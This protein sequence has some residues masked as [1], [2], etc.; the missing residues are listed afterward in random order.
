MNH[1][2]LC[3]LLI[4]ADGY[5]N[6]KDVDAQRINDE[7]T[8][9]GYCYNDDC[10]T[11]EARINALTTYILMLFKS[12]IR[13]D[14]YSEYDECFLMWLS[15][16][17]FKIHSKSKDKNKKITLSQAYDM[18]L[19]KHKAKLGHWFL[20]D[21]IKGLKNAD[22]KYMSEF[23]K[24]LNKI[25]ITIT[26]YSENGTGSKNII[27][28]STECSNQYMMLYNWFSEC[29]SYLH[30]L[31]KLKYIYDRFRKPAMKEIRRNKLSI[32][33]QTLT[34]IAGVEMRSSKVFKSYDFSNSQC[35]SKKK[36]TTIPKKEE[37]PP[38]PLKQPKDSQDETSPPS[39]SSNALPKTKTGE[40][41]SSDVQDASKIDLKTSDNSEGKTKD[42]SGDQGSPGS[43]TRDAS[44]VPGGQIS[45]GN[46][47]GTNI[48]QQGTDGGSGHGTGNRGTSS[49]QEGD[50]GGDKGSSS[51]EN[52]SPVG[53]LNDQVDSGVE[54]GKKIGGA[55]EP[56]DPSDGKGSQV[57]GGDRTSIES[58]G[59]DTGKGGPGNSDNEKGVKDSG[60]GSPS[61][62]TG[63]LGGGLNGQA[64]SG[65]ESRNMN[66]EV[67]EPGAPRGGEGIQINKGDGPNGE[68]D[69][70]NAGKEGSDGGSGSSN[71]EQGG[72]DS[73]PG[74]SSSGTEN[75]GRKSSD[76]DLGSNTEDKKNLQIDKGITQDNSMKQ[77]EGLSKSGGSV[78]NSPKDKEST[79]NTMEQHQQNNSL[80]SNPKEKPQDSQK[81]TPPLQEP[82]TK[83]LEPP[84]LTIPQP[85]Q[86]QPQPS[87]QPEDNQRE[88][89]Q[90]SAS[91]PELKNG[92]RTPDIPPKG[93]SSEQK[94]SG[95]GTENSKCPQSDSKDHPQT[96]ALNKRGS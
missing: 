28:N 65:D 87:G 94:D 13:N 55:K 48:S 11:N 90:P 82:E 72:K 39:Q 54:K 76:K 60:P 10:K 26:D 56:G 78:D 49:H 85:E 68:S 7:P 17:L 25:C 63:N 92:Q 1:E 41:R 27:M 4:E 62:G 20:F 58:G 5:F 29:K 66:G 80:G 75:L 73:Q 69:G 22:L 40:S 21:N 30:L 31:N 19:K 32:P 18:Y 45:N 37:P 91:K 83:E 23:Y 46:Q 15:D 50:P 64:G 8:I 95:G 24:L 71:N 77:H 59:A 89:S 3:G 47:G 67:K 93:P 61:S 33:L 74:G 43:G 84:M 34:T 35:K 57:N 79:N 86:Q 6:G 96:P 2:I 14:D 36:K 16:K 70:K 52:K 44:N 51:S 38:P 42:A 88:T 12:S 53:G 81:G 9:K